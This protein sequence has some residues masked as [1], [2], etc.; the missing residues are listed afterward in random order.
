M[1]QPDPT[2]LIEDI[3]AANFVGVM[4]RNRTFE[5]VY[6]PEYQISGHIGVAG[7]QQDRNHY[8]VY[9]IYEYSTSFILSVAFSRLLFSVLGA[10]SKTFSE[11]GV[12]QH[13]GNVACLSYFFGTTILRKT[14]LRRKFFFCVIKYSFLYAFYAKVYP[15]NNTLMATIAL[16]SALFNKALIYLNQFCFQYENLILTTN[17]GF[18]EVLALNIAEN[19]RDSVQQD[20]EDDLREE[21]YD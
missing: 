17:S 16:Y 10:M 21:I 9:F 3:Q 4:Q 6:Q 11:P 19:L 13:I 18:G 5:T 8:R 12:M 14:Q 15:Y 1:R 2:D 20:L 7:R